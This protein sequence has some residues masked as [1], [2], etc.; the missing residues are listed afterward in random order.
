MDQVEDEVYKSID[1]LN[2]E[3]ADEV[4]GQA[5]VTIRDVRDQIESYIA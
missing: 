1:E 3:F 5:T 4:L 2:G